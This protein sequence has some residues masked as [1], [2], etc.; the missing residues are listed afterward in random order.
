M[1]VRFWGTRGSLAKPGA[2]TVRYGG[3]TSCVEVRSAAGARLVIDCGT[4]GH[5]LG[6]AIM[7]EGKPSRGH[8]L[9]SHTHWDHIQGVPFFTP[10]FVPGHRWDVYAPQGFGESIK[11]TLAGQMEYTYFPVSPEAFGAE[12]KYHNLG[13][14]SFVVDDFVISTRY[15]NHPALA[16]AFRIECDGAVLVYSCDHEPHDAQ[17]AHGATDLTGEDLAHSQF[18]EGADLI[19]HDA[20]YLPAEYDA[21]RGW[22]HSTVDYAVTVAR[23][24]GAKQVALTHHDPL[25]SDDELDAVVARLR[26]QRQPGDPEIV[27]AAEGSVIELVG[28]KP[29]PVETPAITN[30]PQAVR[31]ATTGVIPRVLLVATDDDLA[32]RIAKAANAEIVELTRVRVAEDAPHAATELQP[33]LVLVQDG[34]ADDAA[35]R[36]LQA[37]M[38]DDPA[39]LMLLGGSGPD[40][41]N[42]GRSSRRALVARICPHPHPHLADAVGMPLVASADPARR[43][44]TAGGTAFAQGAGHAARGTLRSRNAACVGAVQGARGAGQPD[45]HEPPVVQVEDRHGHY[46]GA[47]RNV[48]LRPCGRRAYHAHHPGRACG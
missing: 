34:L 6:Q 40:R 16:L 22:G 43:A 19:I 17:L 37:T 25:R 33:A 3:N 35:L 4:G 28:A 10:F 48:V 41:R 23:A 36:V 15:L 45:R 20:Q 32:A 31:A 7:R 9:I 46:R 12:V 29:T 13:E 27:G 2:K 24:A 8:M 47:T 42:R 1:Q 5:E 44:R 21:K 11:E 14:G 30:A 38:G 39:P 18:M 26:E